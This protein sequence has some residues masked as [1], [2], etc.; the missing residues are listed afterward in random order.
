L[1]ETDIQRNHGITVV[2]ILLVAQ[3][4]TRY[5]PD[6]MGSVLL[7]IVRLRYKTVNTLSVR[8]E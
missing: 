4:T 6:E 7:V 3:K 1:L 5:H 8:E 2:R